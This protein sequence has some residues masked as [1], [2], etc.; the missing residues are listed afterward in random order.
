MNTA[1]EV[2]N[3]QFDMGT[4]RLKPSVC[5][6]NFDKKLLLLA[7]CTNRC[8]FW[9][10]SSTT[11]LAGFIDTLSKSLSPQH[12]AIFLSTIGLNWVYGLCVCSRKAG[13]ALRTYGEG[14]I[15]QRH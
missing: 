10:M 12:L 5:S 14:G 4:L 1:N 3:L 11:A 2:N 9:A 7:N 13:K 15:L 6:D 8:A